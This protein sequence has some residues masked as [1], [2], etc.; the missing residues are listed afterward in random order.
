MLDI[1]GRVVDR[2][3]ELTELRT[4]VE[5][6]GR[7]SGGCVLLSGA[8]GVGKSTLTQAF[9]VEVSGR[10]CVFAY[11][12]CRDGAPAPYSALADALSSVVRTM[13]VTGPAERDGWRADL[14]NVMSGFTGVLSE[15]VPEL[16]PVLGESSDDADLDAADARRRLHRAAIRLVSTTASYR[17]V[18]L[19][20]DD[21]QWADRDTLLL[22]S[23][24]LTV[25]P[26]NV[27]VVGAHRTGEFDPS[28][29]GFKSESLNTIELKPLA[30]EDVEEL[31]AAV[32]GQSVELG[33]VAAEF[34]HRTGGNPLQVRQL[35]YRAQREG[36]L[37]PV[38]PGGH[39]SWDL[40]VLMSIEVSATA[41]EFLGRYLEQLRPADRE[42][43]SSLS[44][45]GGEFDLDDATAAAALSPDVVAHT[46]WACLEL[47]LLEALDGGGQRITNAISRDARYRF[48]HDRVAE[49]AR[50][51][52]SVDEMRA[53]HLR[54]GRRLVALGDDRVFE[55]AR[56]VGIGGL[57][58]ADDVERTQFVEAVRRAARKA[59]AQASFPLA[60]GYCRSA[61]DLL[62]EQRW[63][64][65]FELTRELQLDAADAALLVGDVPALNAL[66]DEAEEHLHEPADRARLAYLRLKGRVAENRLQEALEIGLQAL[67]ELGERVAGDAGKPRMNNAI[68]RT[69]LT[70]RRWSNERLLG[71]PHCDDQRVIAL[72]RILAELCNLSVLIR[73][74]LLTLLV[75]KQLDLTLAHGH[76]PSSPLVVTGYGIVLV[77]LGDHA[78]SQRFGEVGMLLAERPEFREARPQTVFMHLDYIRLWRHPIRDGLGELRDAVEEALDQG[79]QEN[80]GFLAAVLL[81][82]SFWV[83][84]PLAEID[85]LASSLIPQI[86]SQPV[87]SALCQAMQQLC[88]NLMG[89]SADPLLLAGESGY[90]ERDVLPAA[91]R[92]GDEVALGVAA[93]MKQGLHFWCGD[94]VGA[95]AATLEAIEHLGGLDGTTPAQLVYLLGALSM[96][97]TAPRERS[98]ARFVHQTLASHRKWAATAPDNYAAPYALIQGAWAHA[99]GQ[100]TKAEHYL[101]QAIELAEKY[102]LPIISARA[103]EQAA[104][105]YAET[106]RTTLHEHMLRSA[107]QRYLNLGFAV[108]TDWLA[109]E[110]PWLLRRDLTGSAGIDPVGAHQLLHALSGARTPDSLANIILGS[111]ADTTGAGRVLFLTGEPENLSVRAI[112]DHGDISIVDGPW[113]EVPYDR[114]IVRRVVDGGAPVIV[115]ADDQPTQASR[116]SIL[117][118]P[119]AVRDKIIGVIY[120]ERD[121][122]GRNFGADHEQ[123]VGFLCAQ[124]A[125][126]LWNFQLEARLRA[127]DEYRQSLMD[128]QSRFV[129]NELLRILDIDDLRRVRSGYRV[130]REMTVLISDIRGYTT[131]IE[132]MNVAEAGNLAMGFLRAVELPIISYHGMIQDVRGDEIVAVFESEADAVRAGLAML[133]S[134]QEHNQE[135]KALGS[136]ELRVGIGINTGAVAVGLV[137]GVNR[138]VLTIIGDAVNLAARIEST[139]KRYGSAVLISDRTKKR[140]A[141]SEQFDVRRMER[142]MVVNRRRPVTIY[143]VYDEDSAALRDAKR[144]A[145]PAFDKAFTLFDAGDVAGARAAFERCRELLPDD[146]VAPLHLAH[147]DAVARGE[148]TPGQDVALLNK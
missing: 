141:D 103:H 62:G 146:P 1:D 43:L 92:E 52:L 101:H 27:L 81:S 104:A 129:P 15:L 30:P 57:G 127:A 37:V 88:L 124:A 109:R 94:Y 56:H 147:C 42:V 89:R 87:P 17:P 115:A 73:P 25:S 64:S 128:V 55:A 66:L 110:H 32:C 4:A 18:V 143:E 70:M 132:D 63:A 96:I 120:A 58:L 83:G 125:A 6:A 72:H 13:E 138:M 36:A 131:I 112:N 7:V 22:L 45:I 11:G 21:L 12:R 148:M 84:R 85:A 53:I 54:I 60:L 117:G 50:A 119:I 114:D 44:C 122:P 144:A 90:D 93:A 79:D 75:R 5:T 9:G 68:V 116:P 49:A 106:G 41:A 16:A 102:Q 137:G 10:N 14:V 40:R 98:T 140:L 97:H 135:R 24:L 65:H 136:E 91:R 99:R 61:L 80:A 35:L 23:E 118:A 145:Q 126:S 33:D 113:T 31:L 78:G 51:G 108:R 74:N 20:L 130:E 39:P 107:Y 133:R 2:R 28:A 142:V 76:T 86:R 69:R 59:R 19:A 123:A 77:L 47:R 121:E 111:V 105:L 48:S 67:D 26:R 34:H 38:G 100:H 29:A 82:Q 134:L 3:Q 46:L 8:P 71:L 95:V 139:N